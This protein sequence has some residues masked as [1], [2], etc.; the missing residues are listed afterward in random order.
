MDRLAAGLTSVAVSGGGVRGEGLEGRH[1][2]VLPLAA[3]HLCSMLYVPVYCY[4][5]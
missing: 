2:A 1:D 5:I 4:L 3:L